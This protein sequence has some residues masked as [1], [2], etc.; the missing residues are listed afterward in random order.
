MHT[1]QA[2]IYVCTDGWQG[3]W[4]EETDFPLWSDRLLVIPRKAN[5]AAEAL[6]V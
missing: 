1:V 2:F 6:T 3:C 4:R 5:M